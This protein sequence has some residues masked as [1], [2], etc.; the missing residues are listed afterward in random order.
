[1]LPTAIVAGLSGGSGKTVAALSL[2]AG[3]KQKGI[4]V[5]PFKKGPDFIDPAWL[6]LVAGGTCRNLDLYMMTRSQI[7]KSHI[8]NSAGSQISVV[9]GNRGLYDGLDENGSCST[10]A[11]SIM[12]NGR[13]ILVLN[14]TKM[15]GTAAAL[16]LGCQRLNPRVQIA[17][18][19][20]NRVAGARHQ[21]VLRKSIEH[22]TNVP[23]VGAI[24]KLKDMP[25]FERHLGLLPPAEHKTQS[26]VVDQVNDIAGKYL[27]IDKIINILKPRVSVFKPT[28]PVPRPLTLSSGS[29]RVGV[30]RD[31]AF[32]FYYPENLEALE[33]QGA[34]LIFIDA[35]RDLQLPSVDLLYIGGGFPETAAA[36]LEKNT[37]FRESVKNAVEKGL[38]VY[39]ECG[40]AVYLGARLHFRSRSYDMAGVFP[41]DY[42]FSERPRGH[43][44]TQVKITAKNPFFKTGALIKGH[45][46]HYT[47]MEA[48]SG[49]RF[50]AR[51]CR[52]EGFGQERE[53]LVYK[54]VFATYTH[55]HAGGRRDWATSLMSSL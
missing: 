42:Q 38:H 29:G 5:A 9:E 40:G 31:K 30:I 46:F 18:V 3:L 52:G 24:P 12:L 20:L 25:I 53:G 43:G 7:L 32:N 23:I 26:L 21:T 39:A 11:L 6:G 45:E 15:T 1:M 8:N 41:V 34:N 4:V 14:C 2:I 22:H 37:S 54:N 16:V 33:K 36:A 10:A 13:V 35:L 44:Y 47:F 17:G 49:L 48:A 51:A 28:L 19:I 55:I 27:D 50:C